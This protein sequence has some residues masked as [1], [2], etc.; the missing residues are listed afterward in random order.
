[1]LTPNF[2][3]YQ[4]PDRRADRAYR[5]PGTQRC[6]PKRVMARCSSPAAFGDGRAFSTSLVAASLLQKISGSKAVWLCRW[7]LET[8][9]P[10]AGREDGVLA[11]TCFRRLF[12]NPFVHDR[13]LCGTFACSSRRLPGGGPEVSN[14]SYS[15]RRPA[16]KP[17]SSSNPLCLDRL[18]ERQ[19]STIHLCSCSYLCI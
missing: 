10:V 11:E 14:K 4:P 5:A 13:H 2:A 9:Q 1:M 17:C 19:Q 16:T 8:R 15:A 12:K 6:R 3:P 7:E 18:R